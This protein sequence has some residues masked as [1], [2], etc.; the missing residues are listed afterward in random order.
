VDATGA[1]DAA[2]LRRLWPEVLEVVKDASRTTRALLDNA[3]IAAVDGELVT[4][5]APGALAKMISEERNTSV[6][7][8]AL[9]KVV[10]GSWRIGV[11]GAAPPAAAV[12][13]QRGR[14]SSEPDP[15]DDEP[16]PA[17]ARTS[18]PVAQSAVDPEADAL[19]LLRDEL[20]ARPLDG[21]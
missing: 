12:S 7:R 16:E 2:A 3:Q 21:A 17:D 8:T 11:D 19:K 6:L 20:G 15:R 10:G 14:D 1:L 18:G 13:A 4:L 5:S 9:T